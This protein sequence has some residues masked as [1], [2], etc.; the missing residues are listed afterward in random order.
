MTTDRFL[1]LHGVSSA[2]RRSSLSWCAALSAD[3]LIV[4]QRQNAAFGLAVCLRPGGM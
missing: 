1:A 2:T 3:L 4:V